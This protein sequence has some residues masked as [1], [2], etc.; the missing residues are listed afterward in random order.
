ME[1]QIKTG[2]K[3]KLTTRILLCTLVLA[4]GISGMVAL[5][6]LKT[7]PA[8]AVYQEKPLKVEVLRAEP[9]DVG[10]MIT[11]FAE[12]RPLDIVD[13]SPEVSGRI[14]E[15][16]PR[17]EAGEVIPEGE[18]LFRIDPRDYRAAHDDARAKV[19]QWE[20]TIARIEKEFALDKARLETLKRNRDL[21][22]AE[23]QRL[24]TLYERDSVGTR[25]GVD[26]AEQVYNQ[27]ADT[28]DQLARQL[29]VY[30]LQIRENQA[31]LASARA[32]LEKTRTNLD[33]VEIRAPFDG[34]LKT[35]SIEEGQY[36]SPGLKAVTLADD[37]VLELRVPLDSRDA[38]KWLRFDQQQTPGN[39][40]LF[41]GLDRVPVTIQ[42]TEDRQGHT[43]TGR[44]H[45][46]IHFDSQ[47]R[48]LLVAVRVD[49]SAADAD[50]NFPLLEGMF[51]EVEIPGKTLEKVV[52]L[53]RWAVSFENTVFVA[54]ENR[55][56]TVPVRVSRIEGEN[57]FIS[58]GL[59]AG[60]RV[61]VTR[62]VDPLENALLEITNGAEAGDR[63]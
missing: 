58:E 33:R 55:L 34:R 28:V 51:C 19:T 60:D 44:L 56:R 37:S 57:A 3:T 63:S 1:S 18:L 40:A 15:V 23:Y 26:Q 4:A 14:I 41:S 49:R 2:S 43:W 42:W 11:G 16:H 12:A 22:E 61:I 59:S 45:R 32:H 9:E 47:T 36:V 25:S 46:V 24:K 62:L 17:L 20:N 13:I 31:A 7:P 54:D 35:V 6:S 48:T 10:V 8:E 38:R 30:P 27:A 53:P 50:G 52:R 21:A 5:A 39:A 29:E